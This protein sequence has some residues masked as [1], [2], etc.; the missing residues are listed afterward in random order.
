MER[1]LLSVCPVDFILG[2]LLRV[3]TVCN[4]L[5]GIISTLLYSTIMA[6]QL[7]HA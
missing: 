2:I 4:L 3:F 5:L 7:L 6:D 1:D